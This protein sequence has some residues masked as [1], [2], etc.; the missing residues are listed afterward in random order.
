MI[1]LHQIEFFIHFMNEKNF[2]FGEP[3]IFLSNR[4]TLNFNK[5]IIAR[6]VYININSMQKDINSMKFF[7]LSREAY[8]CKKLNM[9]AYC[10]Q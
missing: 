2:E 4:L 7:V 5:I 9:L 8:S 10:M 3:S 1:F 6:D